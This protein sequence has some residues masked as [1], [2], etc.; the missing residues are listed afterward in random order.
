M[1]FSRKH[2]LRLVSNCLTLFFSCLWFIPFFVDL[3]IDPVL[4][5][6]ASFE[7]DFSLAC[8]TFGVCTVMAADCSCNYGYSLLGGLRALAQ[9][10]CFKVRFAFF[11]Y[12]NLQ[13]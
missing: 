1:L 11:C 7:L 10:I 6:F 12:F 9:T 2:Y 13:I 3:V 4:R 8:T 5:G